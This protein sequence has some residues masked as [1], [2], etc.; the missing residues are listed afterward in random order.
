MGISVTRHF[1]RL[2]AINGPA[3]S[4]YMNSI[5]IVGCVLVALV[6]LLV[7]FGRDQTISMPSANSNAGSQA[8][9]ESL[10][11]SGRKIGAIKLLREET[12]LGLKEAKDEVERRARN[13]EP[14]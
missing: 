13:L 7:I 3:V 12:G 10:I 11:R 2:K 6:V 9:V 5:L 8:S 4:V 1:L 14:I